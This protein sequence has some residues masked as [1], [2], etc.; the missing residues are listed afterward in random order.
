M[1]KFKEITGIKKKNVA[2]LRNCVVSVQKD[3]RK[4]VIQAQCCKPGPCSPKW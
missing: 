4:T 2:S 1:K 3:H